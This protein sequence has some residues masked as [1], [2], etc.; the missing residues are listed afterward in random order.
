MLD[1]LINLFYSQ[2]AINRRY[3]CGNPLSIGLPQRKRSRMYSS[4]FAKM[5]TPPRKPDLGIYLC[6]LVLKHVFS[7]KN[8]LQISFLWL[9]FG[10]KNTIVYQ[11]IPSGINSSIAGSKLC[12]V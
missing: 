1:A 4:L 6:Y 10:L 8:F 2:K 3:F 12:I 5:K 7:Q 11:I 9:N